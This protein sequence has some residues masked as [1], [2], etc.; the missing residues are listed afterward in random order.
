[1]T[2][3]PFGT[4]L[5]Y[6]IDGECIWSEYLVRAKSRPEPTVLS[7]RQRAGGVLGQITRGV[8]HALFL[9]AS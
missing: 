4:K 6:R 3:T 9:K 8:R 5:V 2:K 7:L 1:M